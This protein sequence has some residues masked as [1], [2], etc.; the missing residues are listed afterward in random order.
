MAEHDPKKCGCKYR[1]NDCWSCGHI[2]H[3]T[4]D[5]ETK[6]K[7]TVLQSYENL[8]SYAIAE[9]AGDHAC[10]YCDDEKSECLTCAWLADAAENI[11]ALQKPIVVIVS[12]VVVQDVSGIPAGLFVH[13]HDYDTDGQI[14][15]SPDD[16]RTKYIRTD[17]NGDNYFLGVF[18]NQFASGQKC[19]ILY[20]EGK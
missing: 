1:G 5:D 6:A 19:V 12:G 4:L 3:E 2:D 11:K 15:L 13:V 9:H 17:D 7:D 18:T 8:L 16:F 20:M 14:P 10:G